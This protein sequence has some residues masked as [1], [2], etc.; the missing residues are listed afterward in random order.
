M[1]YFTLRG[2]RFD[3][4]P[5]AEICSMTSDGA[6]QQPLTN[7]ERIQTDPEWSPDRSAI[8]YTAWRACPGR[9]ASSAS[10]ST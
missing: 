10:G 9:R 1:A 8:A 2:S 7:D 3:G 5:P 6:D 4:L